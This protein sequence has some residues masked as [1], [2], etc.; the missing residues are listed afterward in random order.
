MTRVHLLKALLE[1]DPRLTR[2]L[3]LL[4]SDTECY[5]AYAAN[6]SSIGVKRLHNI[7][8]N[9]RTEER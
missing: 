1:C 8:F 2:S 5:I 9:V 7:G 4:G 3:P 6:V